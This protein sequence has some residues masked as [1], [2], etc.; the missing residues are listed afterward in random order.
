MLELKSIFL[1]H[2][3]K[4]KENHQLIDTLLYI[5]H[6]IMLDFDCFLPIHI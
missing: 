1:E 6:E 2:W 3:T 5:A 4:L